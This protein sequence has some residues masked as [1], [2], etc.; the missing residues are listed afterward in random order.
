MSH[1]QLTDEISA[2]MMSLQ[3]NEELF[4]R[5]GSTFIPPANVVLPDYVD[6]REKG[7]V[8]RVKDQGNCGSCY[9]FGAVSITVFILSVQKTISLLKGT[10]TQNC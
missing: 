5:T 1:L 4:E 9:A 7:A 3:R 8:T 2:N 10:L 6:W